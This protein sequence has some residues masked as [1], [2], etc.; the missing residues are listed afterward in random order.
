[1]QIFSSSLAAIWSQKWRRDRLIP[2][3]KMKTLYT[4]LRQMRRSVVLYMTTGVDNFL[5]LHLAFI[6]NRGE[7][8]LVLLSLAS[9][10]FRCLNDNYAILLIT[11]KVITW[12]FAQEKR[13]LL[14]PLSNVLI[15]CNSTEC[16][17]KIITKLPFLYSPTF[18]FADFIF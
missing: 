2:C 16:R 17:E 9:K 7:D 13:S 12:I 3:I 1:M 6:R 5:S 15:A 4:S 11:E 14:F 8:H 10:P 18:N